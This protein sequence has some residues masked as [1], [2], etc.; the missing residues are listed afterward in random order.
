MSHFILRF[1]PTLFLGCQDWDIFHKLTNLCI[2]T[3]QH[4]SRVCVRFGRSGDGGRIGA[5]QIGLSRH[6]ARDGNELACACAAFDIIA[7]RSPLAHC[8][9]WNVDGVV[10]GLMHLLNTSVSV[11]SWDY[12]GSLA[13]D[14]YS[15][16]NEFNTP[17]DKR[18][19]EIA[20]VNLKIQFCVGI[21]RD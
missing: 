12:K 14:S 20:Q 11:F 19:S 16:S 17:G 6:R 9:A 1:S 8:E 18:L 7:L 13:P 10:I 4:Y 2:S 3:H 5:S 15:H 21:I